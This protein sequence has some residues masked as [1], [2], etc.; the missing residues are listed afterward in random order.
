MINHL[1]HLALPHAHLF[2][3]NSDKFLRTVD[4]QQFQRLLQH[5]VN[6]LGQNLRLADLELEYFPA[7][8]LD[9]NGKL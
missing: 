7:H 6:L 9:Q 2:D 3:H 1:G 5:T 8:H 4:Y